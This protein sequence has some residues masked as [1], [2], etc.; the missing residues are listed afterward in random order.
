MGNKVCC[1]IR[2]V[3]CTTRTGNIVSFQEQQ[4]GNMRSRHGC[5]AQVGITPIG[6]RGKYTNSRGCKVNN[7]ITEI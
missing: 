7:V 1:A 3:L 2:I 5:A 6:K 4:T